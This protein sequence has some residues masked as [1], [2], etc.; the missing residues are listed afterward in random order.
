MANENMHYLLGQGKI[1]TANLLPNGRPGSLRWM[2]DCSK[3]NAT[4]KFETVKLKESFSGL[5]TTRKSIVVGREGSLEI[6]AREADPAN[7]ALALSGVSTSLDD[8]TVTG[9]AFCAEWVKDGR[10][11]LTYPA[12]S[13]VQV[14]D[15]AQVS[16]ILPEERYTVD[17]DFGTITLHGDLGALVLPLKASYKHEAL[18]STSM[19]SAIQKPIFIRYEG[20]NLGN[21]GTPIVVEFYKVAFEPLKDLALIGDKEAEFSLSGDVLLDTSR[22]L[23][24]EMGQFGRFLRTRLA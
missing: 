6:V 2:L 8:G 12:V 10:F 23:S 1:Y 3:C 15:S 14:S 17:P 18:E 22:P 16:V 5:R 20:I 9:E 19:M 7:L 24:T 11:A 13:D 4:F 21:D